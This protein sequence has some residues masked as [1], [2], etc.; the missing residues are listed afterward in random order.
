MLNWSGVFNAQCHASR[1]NTRWDVAAYDGLNVCTHL[2]IVEKADLFWMF[3]SRGLQVSLNVDDDPLK[4]CA[5]KE[6][7]RYDY[8]TC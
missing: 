6:V 3:H 7:T 4:N 8:D 5:S 1:K 2:C